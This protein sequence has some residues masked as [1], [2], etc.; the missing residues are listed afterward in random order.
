MDSGEGYLAGRYL[1]I[2]LSRTVYPGKDEPDDKLQVIDI[3]DVLTKEIR[4]GI[5]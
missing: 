4:D 2:P 1:D 5:E 3:V